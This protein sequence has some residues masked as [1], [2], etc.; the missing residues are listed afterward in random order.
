MRVVTDSTACL[1]DAVD[2]DASPVVVVPLRV[3]TPDGDRRE[4]VDI[5][6]AEV[7]ERIAAGQRLTTSQPAPE[8]FAD[9]YRDLAADGAGAIVSVHLSGDVSGTVGA[10]A[11]AG[12][13]AMVPVRVVDSRTAAM[14]LGFAALAAAECPAH[15]A[16]AEHVA[17]RARE[18]AASS[19][20]LFLVD[21]LDHLRRGGRL[22]AGA[23]ALGAALGVRPILEIV[24]GRVSLVQRVR[25]RAAALDR[26]L[27]IAAEHAAGMER[28]GV[29]VHHLGAAERAEAAAGRLA[30][31]L[32][33][34]PV[35]TPVSAVLGTHAGP[36]ALAVVVAE[37]G[38]HAH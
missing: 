8:D 18:V 21:S 13:R 29:A 7:A 17:A 28:P 3:L 36:G 30:E 2:D 22:S 33:V 20:C 1:P 38:A 6:P 25:T 19:R 24:D 11:H 5:T 12:Q 31:T 10:A 15:G 4:G 27:A 37:L 9:V 26:M 34:V 32:G 14:A 16:D 35:V 23:A